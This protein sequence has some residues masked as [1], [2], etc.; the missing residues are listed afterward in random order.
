MC[1]GN[2]DAET[3]SNAGSNFMM[4]RYS[5]SGG[6]IDTPLIMMRSTGTIYFQSTQGFP[7]VTG[8]SGS[9]PGISCWDT[10]QQSCMGWFLGGGSRLYCGAFSSVGVYV[11]PWYAFFDT[12][13][14]MQISGG[15]A[16]KTGG[17]SWA[18]SSDARVK[19][20]IGEYSK[21]LAAIQK[22]KPIICK[23]KGNDT[24]DEPEAGSTAPYSDSPHYNAATAG[25]EFVSLVAQ[26][27]EDIMP[28]MVDSRTGYID[29]E[30][31]SDIRT[32]DT[33]P[34]TFAMVNALKE[35]ADERARWQR[36]RYRIEPDRPHRL[37]AKARDTP[38]RGG[39]RGDR[40]CDVARRRH[41][42]RQRGRRQLCRAA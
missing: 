24:F 18:A 8:G 26:D 35:L 41:I 17:G 7:V 32:L 11:G 30:P 5:D 33:T 42:H 3:G 6:T 39:S 25:T 14:N 12:S 37:D 28:E 4:N 22:L 21:G 36:Q 27:C 29:G 16:Y 23:Y 2:G 40:P 38:G 15:T 13:G 19:T 31:A 10:A 9:N 34:L 20:V 1:L